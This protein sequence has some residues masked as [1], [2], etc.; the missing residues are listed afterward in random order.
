MTVIFI[1]IQGLE[2]DS[3]EQEDELDDDDLSNWPDEVT[4]KLIELFRNSP[5]LYD[6]SHDLYR[7]KGRKD[8]ALRR[9]AE[10]LDRSGEE[11]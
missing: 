4:V 1:S 7:N 11:K 9:I 10:Q 6:M 2:G 5:I 8:R 3:E